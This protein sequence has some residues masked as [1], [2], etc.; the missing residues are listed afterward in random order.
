[1]KKQVNK[2]NKNSPKNF[3]KCMYGE[4]QIC[5]NLLTLELFPSWLSSSTYNVSFVSSSESDFHV[6]SCDLSS[7][8]N[9]S[10]LS[11]SFSSMSIKV[12]AVSE[13]LSRSFDSCCWSNFF[14]FFFALN[15]LLLKKK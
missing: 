10:S 9:F 15:S 8:F 13:Y 1:M 2:L 4:I 12:R 14:R 6:P 5:T 3:I 7:L 11:L